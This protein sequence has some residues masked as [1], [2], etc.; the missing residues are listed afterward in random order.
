M[1]IAGCFLFGK[2]PKP[3]RKTSNGGEFRF[4]SE[5]LVRAGL[6]VAI[7]DQLEDPKTVA[8][9][10]VKRGVTEL[11][12]P[13]VTFNEQVLTSKKNNF[14]L[15]VHKHKEKYGV[16][17]VDVSTGEFLVSEG[18][19]EKLLHIVHTFD[20]SEIIYQRSTE[21]PAQLKNKN[22]FKLEDWAFQYNYAYEKLTNHFKTASLKGFGIEEHQL[23]IISAGALI[24]NFL[25]SSI[26]KP[27]NEAV[28]KWFVSF[29]YA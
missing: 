26:P 13:G 6:R 4:I 12:T 14:L 3:L 1:K 19:L 2:H 17:L 28:L 23:G 8:K 22:L 7:C 9:G 29:S 18:N 15:S 10:I 25:C 20:P 27:F 16:A 24:N 11:V 21:L 5:K